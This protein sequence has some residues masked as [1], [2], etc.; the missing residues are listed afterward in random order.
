MMF[1]NE[2]WSHGRNKNLILCTFL[3]WKAER[4]L[5]SQVVSAQVTGGRVRLVFTIRVFFVNCISPILKMYFSDLARCILKGASF[6]RWPGEG[7]ESTAYVYYPALG[8]QY[9]CSPSTTLWLHLSRGQ[10]TCMELAETIY[11]K[12]L[13]YTWMWYFKGQLVCHETWPLLKLGKKKGLNL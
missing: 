9:N 12:G 13:K 1:D 4:C 5:L 8:R 11:G 3:L 10:S 7:K 6:P 2:K